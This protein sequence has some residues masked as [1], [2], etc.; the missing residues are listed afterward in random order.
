MQFVP[1]GLFSRS[2]KL[3]RVKMLDTGLSSGAMGGKAHGQDERIYLVNRSQN[4][5]LR[6]DP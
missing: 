5:I 1:I 3:Q 6:L 2:V 4:Q